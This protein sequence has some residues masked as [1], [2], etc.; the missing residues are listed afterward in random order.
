MNEPV[1]LLPGAKMPPWVEDLERGNFGEV[2][3]PLEGHEHLFG[4]PPEAYI[5]WT[6]IPA[7]QEAELLRVAVA[8]G[9]RRQ[10]LARR[11]LE[12]SERFLQG[13][14]IRTLHLEVRLS[15]QA[16]RTLYESTGW[17]LQG[18]RKAYYRD[19]EDAVLYR[20]QL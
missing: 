6:V 5:R 17:T 19:G 13:V 3:G 16:A 4:L 7:A 1:H 15:N 18:L 14:G 12:A 20:K 10:G 2:W 9:T 8:P 11:L